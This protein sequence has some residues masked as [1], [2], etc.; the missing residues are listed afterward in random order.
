MSGQDD[1]HW[2]DALAGRQA[3]DSSESVD[4]E[5]RALRALISAQINQDTVSVAKTDLAREAALLARAK[6][7]GL[8]PTPVRRA[9]MSVPVGLAA[10]VVLA[11][12]SIGLY[13]A[14]LPP[15]ETFRGVQDGTVR[16]S[17]KDPAALR[18]QLIRE[19]RSA[20][21]HAVAYE[22]FGRLG[23]D[24]EMTKPI[25]A[26]LRQILERHHIPVPQ[27]AALIIEIDATDSK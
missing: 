27:D 11:S 7:Q 1:L 5:A 18:D 23:I 12:A 9:W 21:V 20:G 15:S 2:L 17:A 4:Q 19:L 22:R 25:S 3:S 16:L 13:R 26:P 6:A 8:V 10:A 14:S 24:A